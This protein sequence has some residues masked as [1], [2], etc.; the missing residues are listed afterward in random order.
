MKKL[1]KLLPLFIGGIIIIILVVII[2]FV[3]EFFKREQSDFITSNEYNFSDKV[4][5]LPGT[6]VY[7][8]PKLESSHCLEGICIDDA[9][10]YYI[11]DTGRVDYL[12]TNN[13][14]EKK[15][16]YLKMKFSKGYLLIA[17]RNLG[18]GASVKTTS[19]YKG[20]DLSKESDYVLENLSEK[21]LSEIEK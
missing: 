2:I 12:I 20:F 6:V 8:N 1:T 15:S 14:D 11:D 17:Y 10:F 4:E 16:G 9:T 7:S 3:F 5:E 13:S 18:V 21:E 19:Q